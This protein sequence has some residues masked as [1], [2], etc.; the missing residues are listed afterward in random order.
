MSK[1]WVELGDKVDPYKSDFA[2]DTYYE[3]NRRKD[4]IQKKLEELLK[5]ADYD[6]IDMGEEKL[7]WSF[8][9]CNHQ[10]RYNPVT[11]KDIFNIMDYLDRIV[12]ETDPAYLS[13]LNWE[14]RLGL[15][16]PEKLV[17]GDEYSFEFFDDFFGYYTAIRKDKW[18]D[19]FLR[20]YLKKEFN[21]TELTGWKIRGGHPNH[22][23]FIDKEAVKLRTEGKAGYAFY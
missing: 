21:A 4:K 7:W 6:V 11:Y 3:K 15:V 19:E 12:D 17:A 2:V 1:D 8:S 23:V 14:N 22:V 18:S 9:L 10:Y 13:F 20:W 5:D 16:P